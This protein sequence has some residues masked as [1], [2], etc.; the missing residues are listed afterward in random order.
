MPMSQVPV[1]EFLGDLAHGGLGNVFGR[2]M[3]LQ[4]LG[5]QHALEVLRFF[6]SMLASTFNIYESK[7]NCCKLWC[8]G[9]TRSSFNHRLMLQKSSETTIQTVAQTVPHPTWQRCFKA[10]PPA[11]FGLPNGLVVEVKKGLQ[12]EHFWNIS[13]GSFQLKYVSQN[14]PPNVNGALF[15]KGLFTMVK[16]NGSWISGPKV[17]PSPSWERSFHQVDPCFHLTVH[18]KASN[19]RWEKARYQD[20]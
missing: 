2:V 4:F 13:L 17:L 15:L 10:T 16:K 1:W 20:I 5:V 18:P 9:W 3:Q 14:G 19:R 8:L 6:L 11:P 12:P 7:L